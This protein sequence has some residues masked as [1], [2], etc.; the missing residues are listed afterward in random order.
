MPTSRLIR[1]TCP[2]DCPDTCGTIVEVVDGRAVGFRGDPDHPITQGWLCGKV[3]PYLEHVYH[4][5]RLTHP[6]RRVGP[7]G[8]GQFERITW[9]EAIGEI[10]DRW[11]RIIADYGAE[12]ILPYSYSG[13]LGLVNMGVSS[14]RFWNRLGASQLDRAICGAAA[15][16]AVEATLGARWAVPYADTAHSR[17]ILIWG[18]NPASTAPHFMP[19][20]KDAQRRGCTVVVI[21]PR[22]TR[23]ARTADWH[24]APRPGSDGALALSLAHVIV[25]EGLHDETWLAAHTVG[26]PA[27]RERI[28]EYPPERAAEIA[29]LPVED[30]VKLARLYATSKPGLIKMA[31]GL[32][33]NRMGGQTV[34][35][36]LALPALTGQYGL[37]GGGLAYS[38]SGYLKWDGEAVNKWSECPPPGRVV[39]M[40]RLGA[41]LLGEAAD[42]PIM[43]LY[44]FG[45]NPAA[46]APNAGAVVAGLTRDDLF[47]VVHELFLTDTADYADIVLPATSNLEQADLH[48]AYGHT[49]LRYNHPA[50]PPLDESLSNWD[51]V[52]RLAAE[53]GF[54][55]PWLRQDADE[56]IAEVLAA[57]ATHNPRLA[58]ITLVRLKREGQLPLT[59]E[60]AVPFADGH[61][62]TPSGKVELY[63]ARLAADGHDPLPGYTGE[64]D[65]GELPESRVENNGGGAGEQRSR[66]AVASALPLAP[67]P[68]PLTPNHETRFPAQDALHLITPAAHHF[69]TSSLGNGRSQLRGEGPPTIEIHPDDAAARGIAHGDDV[70]VENGRGCVTLRAVV[71]DG[72]RPGVVAAPK[73]R[74]GKLGDGR[75]QRRNV[76]WT[77]SDALGDFAGQSTFHSNKVWLRPARRQS[78]DFTDGTD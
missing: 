76:N 49:L 32:Q 11:R 24:V 16:Y 37:R 21:D 5:D 62:P 51:V 23:T 59:L 47:T 65:D 54:D 13:T 4:P 25:Q 67:G 61:F 29:G 42:P 46:I 40:N 71:T 45:S 35:A 75:G 20:L 41:A 6:L 72:V 58:G 14:G 10:G 74:W 31:D 43:S 30:V 39:N 3:R 73:G 77:T 2:H 26:W 19:F 9:D 44:V 57:T 33:R 28:M 50:I 18:H 68:Y 12:A 8:A 69:V 1:A 52:R 7:K 60:P 56:V 78:T 36:I 17:L 63:S 15:E 70:V 38:T 22:R 53:M 64:D 66:A 34:R 27:L 55:E 48:K